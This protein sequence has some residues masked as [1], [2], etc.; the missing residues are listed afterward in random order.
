MHLSIFHTHSI[1][2]F[3][4]WDVL[5]RLVAAP[6]ID[7]RLGCQGDVHGNYCS[8]DRTGSC[9]FQ[10]NKPRNGA[11]FDRHAAPA[12]SKTVYMVS[13]RIDGRRQRHGN[14]MTSVRIV[15][16]F[17]DT[18]GPRAAPRRNFPLA[19]WNARKFCVRQV[20]DG[21]K[22]AQRDCT[23]KRRRLRHVSGGRKAS[24]LGVCFRSLGGRFRRRS[25]R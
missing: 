5:R 7:V 23:A 11:R 13:A 19:C 6:G 18:A 12:C 8:R 10:R 15:D 20:A 4:I 17:Q 14:A 1:E 22:A 2:A 25:R 24:W 21:W 16:R 9:S 3:I